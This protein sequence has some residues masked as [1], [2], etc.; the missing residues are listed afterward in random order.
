MPAFFAKYC[1]YTILPAQLFDIVK[2]VHAIYSHRILTFSTPSTFTPCV[3]VFLSVFVF[4][5][6]FATYSYM[7][8]IIYE[9][10]RMP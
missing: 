8:I 10:K 2:D 9:Y 6:S 3:Y 4:I 5:N 7:I 1:V